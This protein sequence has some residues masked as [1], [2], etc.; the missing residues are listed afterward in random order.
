MSSLD[1]ASEISCQNDIRP[2]LRAEGK[3]TDQQVIEKAVAALNSGDPVSAVAVARQIPSDSQPL[4][5]TKCEILNA[6]GVALTAD[7]MLQEAV[8]T[9]EEAISINQNFGDAHFNLG[10]AW[11]RKDQFAKACQHYLQALRT[12]PDDCD[13]LNNLLLSLKLSKD[14]NLNYSILREL[15]KLTPTGNACHSSVLSHLHEVGYFDLGAQWMDA[16]PELDSGS[17]W[18]ILSIAGNIFQEL[19]LYSKAITLQQRALEHSPCNKTVLA[20]LGAALVTAGK[21]EEAKSCLVPLL[22]VDSGNANAWNNLGI[23]YDKSG[24]FD[25]AISAF[26]KAIELVSDH[27]PA[28]ENLARICSFHGLSDRADLQYRWLIS[29]RSQ[30]PPVDKIREL[31]NISPIAESNEYIEERR[32]HL[33][34]GLRDLLADPQLLRWTD[35]NR[36]C[37]ITPFILAYQPDSN[38]EINSMLSQLFCSDPIAIHPDQTPKSFHHTGKIRIAF[39]SSFFCSH[40]IAKLNEGLIRGLDRGIFEVSVIVASPTRC[41]ATTSRISGLADH[42]VV[43]TDPVPEAVRKI[44]SG[45]FDII[46]FTDIGMDSWTYFLSMNRMAPVQTASWGHPDTTGI[47]TIDYFISGRTI[48]ADGSENHY[49]EQLIKFRNAP[50]YMEKLNQSDE[51]EIMNIRQVLN[52]HND[53]H[54]YICPQTLFKIH[55]NFDYILEGILTRDDRAHIIFIEGNSPYWSG[56]LLTRWKKIPG[57]DYSRCHFVARM[58]G[59]SFLSLIRSADVVLDPTEFS[60]GLSTQEIL[61]LGKAVI[62]LPGE[63]MRSR[64]TAGFLNQC[65]LNNLIVSNRDTYI[66]LAVDIAREPALSQDLENKIVE[67]FPLIVANTQILTEFENFFQD[68]VEATRNGVRLGEWYW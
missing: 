54:I 17:D 58:S 31:L 32:K 44:R 19:G 46:H 20:N 47:K 67:R 15:Q 36:E 48:E 16:F 24:E 38:R 52:I 61:S 33:R 10:N 25:L 21:V 51:L 29:N 9:F 3:L 41:D 64:V 7:G 40:T 2:E 55:P 6:A 50:V 35:P 5:I 22:E 37:G 59:K 43:L 49:S 66:E 34:N 14:K 42:S 56:Q 68:V 30:R 12:S 11:F 23:A 13:Y 62:T 26:G 1:N 18:E 53:T 65:G 28:R 45:K 57:L 39:I 60:G 8:A 63:F 27:I 4:Q